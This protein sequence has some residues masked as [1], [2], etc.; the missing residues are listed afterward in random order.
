[1]LGG[2]ASHPSSFLGL[3]TLR[4]VF[5]HP[6]TSPLKEGVGDDRMTHESSLD[7][8]CHSHELHS[9]R[10]LS[11]QGALQEVEYIQPV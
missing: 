11:T 7:F 1:M 10:T 4:D 6:R 2:S 8:D 9:A 5:R 3:R